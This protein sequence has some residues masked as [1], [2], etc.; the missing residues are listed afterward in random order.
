MQFLRHLTSEIE[1]VSLLQERIG[2]TTWSSKL[3]MAAD[4]NEHK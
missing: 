2:G 1:T 3:E 4:N